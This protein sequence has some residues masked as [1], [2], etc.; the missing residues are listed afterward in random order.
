MCI[1]DGIAVLYIVSGPV[2]DRDKEAQ[3]GSVR[4]DMGNG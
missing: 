1:G 4:E 3:Q 2:P